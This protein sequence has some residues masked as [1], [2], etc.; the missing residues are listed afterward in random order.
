MFDFIAYPIG[1]LLSLIYN[2]FNNYGVS[3]ILLTL[4]IK[5]L[6]YPL[7]I[8]QQKSQIKSSLFQPKIQELQKKHAND[9]AKLNEETQKLYTEEGHNP[10][11]G[12]L[13]MLI[14]LP[15]IFGLY[16]V[17]SR[18][19]TF[20]AHVSK[21]VVSQAQVIAKSIDKG[22]VQEINI[23]DAFHKAPDKFAKLGDGFKN[24]IN[25]IDLN[26][27]GMD[28][29]KNPK[30]ALTLLIIIPVLSGLTSYL[31]SYVSMKK[32]PS[33]NQQ[34]QMGS[35]KAMMYVMPLM[36][37]GFTLSVPAGVGLYWIIS[38]IFAI[39]QVYVL[40]YFYDP[41]L[42]KQKYQAEIDE[43]KKLQKAKSKS[44]PVK[45]IESQSESK[46][47]SLNKSASDKLAEAR[48]K[49]AEKYGD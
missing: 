23:I 24:S 17:I 27:L 47:E 18:P 46:G 43:K 26:F 22:Y 1:Y 37:F 6:T 39:A 2:V 38:N 45:E 34:S 30:L 10:L 12:C 28:L 7:A 49:M 32:A 11:S 41:E 21:S 4:L 40:N 3:I 9:K 20:I 25:N 14:Q 8:K 44:K 19:L 35:L 16:S 33:A 31:V 15:I 36:S 29:G 48:K 42:L 13:P 5:V